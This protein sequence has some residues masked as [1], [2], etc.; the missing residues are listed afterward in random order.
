[1][2]TVHVILSI[3][4][5]HIYEGRILHS[6][7]TVPIL[8]DFLKEFELLAHFSEKMIYFAILVYQENVAK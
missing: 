6:V 8:T 2:E 3:F 7:N 5:K 1:M 4:P